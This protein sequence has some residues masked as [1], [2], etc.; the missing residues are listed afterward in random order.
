MLPDLFLS[1]SLFPLLSPSPLFSLFLISSLRNLSPFVVVLFELNLV[2][3]QKQRWLRT[4]LASLMTDPY[5]SNCNTMYPVRMLFSLVTRLCQTLCDPMDFSTPGF[6]A[7]HQ[8]PE[9]T[10]THIHRKLENKIPRGSEVKMTCLSFMG[11]HDFLDSFVHSF[12][13]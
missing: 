9:P 12:I 3:W 13:H 8:L 5:T 1:V 4:N 11:R 2:L 6:R 10:Q 7:H